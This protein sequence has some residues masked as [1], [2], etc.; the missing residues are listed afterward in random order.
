MEGFTYHNIFETK[1]IEYL[2]IIGFF[3]ILIPFYLIL[4]KR[5]KAARFLQNAF[6]GLSLQS[7]S[8]PQGLYF[9]R[10]HTWAHLET[11]GNARVG[12]DDFLAKLTG[13]VAFQPVRMPGDNI[14]KGELLALLT[15]QGKHLRVCSPVSG[16]IVEGNPEVLEDSGQLTLDPF[17]KGW[18]FKV[19]PTQWTDETNT[20]FLGEK[21]NEW[22]S[23][24][25]DRLKSWLSGSVEGPDRLYSG[26]VLQDGG[27]LIDQPLS[28]LSAEA[29]KEFQEK[30]L[31]E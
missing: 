29:W 14:R 2:L 9:S 30:F 21:A 12:M 6:R 5:V 11:S 28:E 7:I 1:G 15:A 22:I 3:I 25:L 31:S 18:L 4:S 26:V 20:Y 23:Q 10:F 27:E 19:K 8:I 24:E 17:G 13:P 16:Q